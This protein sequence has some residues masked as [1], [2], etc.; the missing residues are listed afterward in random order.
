M[1]MR[2][3]ETKMEERHPGQDPEAD[4]PPDE[5]TQACTARREAMA[6]HGREA[7]QEDQRLMHEAEEQARPLNERL[8]QAGFGDHKGIA[9][10]P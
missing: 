4:R 9:G 6:K 2:T 10:F 8:R 5:R 1:I 3:E 7:D